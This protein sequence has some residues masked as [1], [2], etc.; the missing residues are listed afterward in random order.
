MPQ[1]RTPKGVI[2]R[3][4]LGMETKEEPCAIGNLMRAYDAEC[5][6]FVDARQL[7]TF[8][9]N[10]IFDAAVHSGLEREAALEEYNRLCG[11]TSQAESEAF[12]KATQAMF[13]AFKSSIEEA[14]ATAQASAAVI[15]S[16]YLVAAC[17]ANKTL[18]REDPAQLFLSKDNS[19]T[20]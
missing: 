7:A 15:L 17:A 8:R 18:P 16:E 1:R 3:N 4:A 19:S 5:N 9:M 2:D 20:K 10:K 13:E 12:D 6:K 11:A 14:I